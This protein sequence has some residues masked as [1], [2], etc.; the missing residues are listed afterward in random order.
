[1]FPPQSVEVDGK[2]ELEGTTDESAVEVAGVTSTEFDA[3]LRFFY[4]S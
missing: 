1:M 4:S 2:E 3:L